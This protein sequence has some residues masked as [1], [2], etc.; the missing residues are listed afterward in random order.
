[1][2]CRGP[3]SLVSSGG[4]SDPKDG[5]EDTDKAS[6]ALQAPESD[7]GRRT[8][9]KVGIGAASAG[10]AGIVAVPA[11]GFVGHPLK[12]EIVSKLDSFLPAGKSKTYGSD[13]VKVYLYSDRRDAWSTLKQVK[14]GSA[15][16]LE[17][18][19]EL[20]ALSTIC[21]HLGCSVDWDGEAKKFKCPCHTSSF[22]TTGEREAGPAPRGMDRLDLKGGEGLIQIRYQRFKQGVPDKETL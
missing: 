13:P 8:F 4:M 14:V 1:M 7:E 17:D 16:V 15:W 12:H 19:G 6:P 21:P 2:R 9:M 18:K 11:L 20:I 10:L 22:S 5:A 3:A